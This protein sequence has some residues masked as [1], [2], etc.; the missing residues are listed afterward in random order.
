MK[1]FFG[2]IAFLAVTAGLFTAPAQ[3]NDYALQSVTTIRQFVKFEL[4]G[5]RLTPEGW[6]SAANEF[7]LKPEP[8]PAREEVRVVTDKFSVRLETLTT[9]K[10]ASVSVSFPV[11]WGKIDGQLH[12]EPSGAGSPSNIPVL[13]YCY[14]TYNLVLSPQKWILTPG[15]QLKPFRDGTT[16]LKLRIV[17][18]P[19]YF[20]L[21][22]TAAIRYATEMRDE[23]NDPVVKKN[24]D[25]TIETLNKL[26]E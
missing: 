1:H 24:A 4:T 25:K 6:G 16:T 12:F 10:D 19:K 21:D 17:N 18:F 11:C 26:K 8:A 23:S 15:G 22:R 7:F 5:G 9:A 14:E 2:V 13:A 20:V 3:E